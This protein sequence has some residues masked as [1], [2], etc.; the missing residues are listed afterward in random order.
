M[1]HPLLEQAKEAVRL[2]RD[3]CPKD[4]RR[5]TPAESEELCR[6]CKEAFLA[7]QRAGTT[8]SE[9]R[10]QLWQEERQAYRAAL[11]RGEGRV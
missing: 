9:M 11:M 7:C 10:R 3:F 4:G 2:S 8:I 1:S 6:L 5:F